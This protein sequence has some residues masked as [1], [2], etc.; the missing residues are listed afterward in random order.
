MP[1]CGDRITLLMCLFFR[2]HQLYISHM[3]ACF[4]RLFIERGCENLDEIEMMSH[5]EVSVLAEKDPNSTGSFVTV[6]DS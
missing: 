3:L 4:Q 5:L 6:E 1:P 2:Q